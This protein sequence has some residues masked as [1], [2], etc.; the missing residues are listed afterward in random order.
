MR[1]G[2]LDA[3]RSEWTKLWTLRSTAYAL[4]ATVVLAMGFEVL[5]AG[6]AGARFGELPP[7]RQAGF[8]PTSVSLQAVL[9]FT[10]VALGL[11]GVLIITSEY[12]TG[13]I[14]A[15]LAAVPRRGRLFAAKAA[16]LTAVAAATGQVVAF[17]A[18]LLGQHILASSGAPAANLG[19]PHVLRAVVCGG[20]YLAL[21]GLLGVALGYLVRSTAGAITILVSLTIIDLAVLPLLP[22]V[23]ARYYP[24]L[25]GLQIINVSHD[26]RA[27]PPWIGFGLLIALVAVSLACGYTAFRT[28]D[29]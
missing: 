27:L 15:S 19:D 11:L 6:G 4:V 10:Q 28:R 23:V 7:E 29:V 3:V 24:V 2:L 9:L 16:V 21:I 14:R 13:T 17:G 25:A 18:F 5:V 20:A 8:D 1:A 12:A 22:A 26:P